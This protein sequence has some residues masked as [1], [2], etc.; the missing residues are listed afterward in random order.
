MEVRYPLHQ[1]AFTPATILI[2]VYDIKSLNVTSSSVESVKEYG[3]ALTKLKLTADL[4]K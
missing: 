3:K 2:C 1:V 4:V